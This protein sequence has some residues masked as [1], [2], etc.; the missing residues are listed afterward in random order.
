[1]SPVVERLDALDAELG[2]GAPP[3]PRSWA[4]VV[5]FWWVQLVLS[6]GSL[7][8]ALVWDLPGLAF[9]TVG[10][11]FQAGYFYNERLRAIGRRSRL[12]GYN[13]PEDRG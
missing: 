1:M 13:A 4:L 12:A 5:R 11:G 3:T 7:V 6:V 9:L 10:S 2:V 8:A